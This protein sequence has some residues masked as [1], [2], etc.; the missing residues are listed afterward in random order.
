M[1]DSKGAILSSKGLN[2]VKVYEHKMRTGSVVGFDGA[3]D[4]TDQEL[5]ELNCDI[6]IPAAMEN[7]I[8]ETNAEVIKARIIAEGA[9]GPTTPRASVILNEKGIFTIPD[10]LANVGGVTVSYFE[11]VQNLH[12][13]HWCV[14]EVNKKLEEKMVKAFREVVETA[15]KHETDMRTG[16]FVLAVGTVAEAEKSLGLW[17]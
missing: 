15:K 2:P 1:S 8:T 13:E 4:I 5:F 6:L 9:N 10:I 17:P 3:R 11:W 12:R 14:E 16:A 7:Q